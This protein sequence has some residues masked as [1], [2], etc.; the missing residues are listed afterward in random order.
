[1]DPSASTRQRCSL[2]IAEVEDNAELIGRPD[3]VSDLVAE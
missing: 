1:M 2:A 3:G